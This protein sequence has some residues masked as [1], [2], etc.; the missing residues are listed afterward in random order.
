MTASLDYPELFVTPDWLKLNMGRDDVNVVDGSWHMPAAGRDAKAEFK[1]EHIPGAVFF[2]IDRVADTSLPLPHMLPEPEMFADAAGAM[3]IS[4]DDTVVIY[5][6]VGLFSAARVWW[7]FTVMGAENVRIL[8]GGLPAWKAAGFEVTDATPLTK[9]ANFHPV[10]NARQV[11]DLADMRH[12]IAKGDALILDARPRG[13]FEGRDPEPREG[14]PS[15]HMPGA[16]SLPASDLIEN[17]ALVSRN[18][19]DLLFAAVGVAGR[20]PV[21]TTCGSGVTAAIIS[22]ALAAI[23]HDNRALYDGSWTEW[24]GHKDSEIV[25]D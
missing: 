10:F 13:R 16:V 24:A 1:A 8:E 5:D 17:G 22:L 11:L 20:K 25:V 3:G 7:T 14:L 21:I 9:P 2:D 4:E 15:G 18:K 19:L 23:G 6:S 12:E